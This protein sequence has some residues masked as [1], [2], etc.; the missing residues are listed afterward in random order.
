MTDPRYSF[1]HQERH[2]TASNGVV[3]PAVFCAVARPIWNTLVFRAVSRP[4]LGGWARLSVKQL[5]LQVQYK[6]FRQ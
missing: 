1:F 3:H 2:E 4:G 6:I 5:L